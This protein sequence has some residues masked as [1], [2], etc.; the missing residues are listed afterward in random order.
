[1]KSKNIEELYDS[2]FEKYELDVVLDEKKIGGIIKNALNTFLFDKD[3]PA[4]YANGGHTKM[5]MA[6]YM[7]ELKKV[8]II[9]DNYSKECDENGFDIISDNQI[10][11]R[12][13]DGIVISSFKFRKEIKQRLIEIVP[14]IPVLDIYEVIESE[15][16]NLKSDYYYNNHPFHHYKIINELIRADDSEEKYIGLITKAL[17]IKDLGLVEQYINKL[18][19][20][21][22][23]KQYL[24]MQADIKELRALFQ[25]G[26]KQIQT[27]NI[28]LLCLDGLRR[29]DFSASKMPKTY[30]FIQKNGVVWNNMYSYS[31]S[32]FESLMP[33]YSG[34]TNQKSHSYICNCV[35]DGDCSFINL[36]KRQ[37]RNIYFYTDMEHYI[38][39]SCIHYH[40]CFQTITQK[41][42]EFVNRAQEEKNG[43]FLIHELYETHYSF[44]NPYTES[45]LL[46]EGTAMLFDFLPQ[47]GGRLRTDYVKQQSDA[48]SYVDDVLVDFFKKLNCKVVIFADHGNIVLEKGT[49]IEDVPEIN[50]TCSEEWTQIPFV[51]L[52]YKEKGKCVNELS[53]LMSL[54]GIV[55]QMLRNERI[56]IKESNY[57]KLGRSEIYNPDFKMLYKNMGYEEDL[58][59]FEAFVFNSGEKLIVFSDG[60]R[61]LYFNDKQIINLSREKDLFEIVKSDITVV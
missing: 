39:D 53:S 18:V 17:H 24:S 4:I 36:A 46:A 12:E 23:K 38:E 33:V 35:S 55:C 56:T 26:I 20:I 30:A 8:K 52:N 2:I 25:E 29:Q 49:K 10:Y 50:L 32:T 22:P 28:L 21:Y 34:N 6:D 41:I 47:K 9:I 3:N 42:W 37:K 54:S 57:I 1:M 43:L 13:V 60:S 5:L 58:K 11:D 51:V 27:D 15:G 19:R 16:I 7:Y 48:L 14:E 31:T 61:K 45:R 44:S 40:E 59:A